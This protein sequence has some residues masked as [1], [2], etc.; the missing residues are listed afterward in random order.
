MALSHLF[1]ER[2]KQLEAL[3]NQNKISTSLS[4]LARAINLKAYEETR[5]G[6]IID[7]KL[8]WKI[9]ESKLQLVREKEK[10]LGGEIDISEIHYSTR[11]SVLPFLFFIPQ[12]A[13]YSFKAYYS[14][15]SEIPIEGEGLMGVVWERKDG[16]NFIRDLDHNERADSKSRC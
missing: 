5:T 8:F 9:A 6:M 7:E 13:E 1:P 4:V 14:D 11:M 15:G 2:V 12:C 10:E 3:R 16:I